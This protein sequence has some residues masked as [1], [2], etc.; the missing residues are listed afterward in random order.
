[1]LK[2]DASRFLQNRLIVKRLCKP[3]FFANHPDDKTICKIVLQANLLIC[4]IVLHPISDNQ[5]GPPVKRMPIPPL[6]NQ[7][8]LDILHGFCF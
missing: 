7:L 2:T 3:F 4:K 1:M 6:G 5:K 8:F